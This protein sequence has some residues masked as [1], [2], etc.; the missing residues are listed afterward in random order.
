MTL[1]IPIFVS[2]AALAAPPQPPPVGETTQVEAVA[3]V[4]SLW[5]ETSARMLIGMDGNA[6]RVGDLI[7]VNISEETSTE[8]L[9]DTEASR[10]STVGGG[11]GSLFGLGTSATA[12]N[13]NLNGE[14]GLSVNGNAEFR[15][16]GSTRREGNLTGTLTCRVIEV[17]TN[18]NLIVWGWKEVRSNRETQYLVLTGTVRPRDIQADNTVLSH[19]LA[20]SRIEFSGQGTVSDKQGPGFGHR[21]MDHA[22]PF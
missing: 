11:I 9:A 12:A 19:L 20:E 6:R 7:T 21:V 1:L 13:S 8:I 14:I 16:D 17:K 3:A 10:E 15:G 5:N 2:G 22:W 4:G 18:G